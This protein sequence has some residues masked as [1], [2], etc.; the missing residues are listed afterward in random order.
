MKF[1]QKG[2]NN[3]SS[4]DVIAL[5][6]INANS[7]PDWQGSRAERGARPRAFVPGRNHDSN[8]YCYYSQRLG[9]RRHSYRSSF[10]PRLDV[11]P[12]PII[13]RSYCQRTKRTK[14]MGRSDENS[15][16]TLLVDLPSCRRCFLRRNAKNF[17]VWCRLRFSRVGVCVSTEKNTDSIA[18]LSSSEPFCPY[19]SGRRACVCSTLPVSY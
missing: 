1:N 17:L 3:E 12:K 10:R 2:I 16:S 7:L 13:Y 19:V 14:Y 4:E 6:Y 8:S 11:D 5:H 15:S 9:R 18:T